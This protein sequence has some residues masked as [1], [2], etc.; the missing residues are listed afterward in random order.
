MW[1]VRS[2]MVCRTATFCSNGRDGWT[3]NSGSLSFSANISARTGSNSCYGAVPRHA[4]LRAKLAKLIAGR[5]RLRQRRR[6]TA[7]RNRIRRPTLASMA[8]SS[9]VAPK[10]QTRFITV[11]SMSIKQRHGRG[12]HARNGQSGRQRHRGRA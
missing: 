3:L 8:T 11:A 6:E 9:A 4:T 5:V 10:F 12:G 7:N 1:A 2:P